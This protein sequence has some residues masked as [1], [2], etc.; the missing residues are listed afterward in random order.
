MNLIYINSFHPEARRNKFLSP[1][2]ELRAQGT[3]R[4]TVGPWHTSIHVSFK[5]WIYCTN[6]SIQISTWHLHHREKTRDWANSQSARHPQSLPYPLLYNVTLELISFIDA[7]WI[8][9]YLHGA[10]GS[11]NLYT[12]LPTRAKAVQYRR[13]FIHYIFYISG[14]FCS[15][16]SGTGLCTGLFPF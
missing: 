7:L 3:L 5:I 6:E 15:G 9:K 12:N 14:P 13:L 11:A 4:K 1:L 16:C 8:I 10:Y 2:W